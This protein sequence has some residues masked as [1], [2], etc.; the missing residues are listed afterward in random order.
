M[1]FLFE[2][3]FVN[4]VNYEGYAAKF[5]ILFFYSVFGLC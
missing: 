5:V 1:N 3:L 4:F 2:W